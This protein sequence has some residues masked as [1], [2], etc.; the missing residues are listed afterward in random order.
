MNKHFISLS[1]LLAMSSAAMAQSWP[2]ARPE[3]KAG[4]RWWWLGSAVDRQNIRWNMEQY[5]AHGAGAVEITP[6]YGVKGNEAN[7]IEYLSPKWMDILKFVEEEGKRTGI[8]V[9]MATGTGWPFG[10][11]SV[12]LEESASQ[13]RPYIIKTSRASE[14]LRQQRRQRIRSLLAFMLFRERRT[15]PRLTLS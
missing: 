14:W 1:I 8:E 9:D 5:A 13:I 15:E 12:P 10:G 4:L 11:P 6:I 2:E 3:A 7:N